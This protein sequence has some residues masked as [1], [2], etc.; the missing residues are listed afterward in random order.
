MQKFNLAV[1]GVWRP[2]AETKKEFKSPE[3]ENK[4][5]QRL[6]QSRLRVWPQFA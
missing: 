1:A 3:L 4:Q 2:G 5:P 6:S